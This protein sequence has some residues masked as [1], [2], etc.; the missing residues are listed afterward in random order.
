MAEVENLVLDILRRLQSDMADLKHG[1]RSIRDE[2][3]GVRQQLHVMQ[4]D[5]MSNVEKVSI[6]LTQEMAAFVRHTVESGEYASNGE[7]IRE[8]LME[9]KKRRDAEKSETETLR[10]LWQEGIDS[11]PGRFETIEDI[12]K[13]AKRRQKLFGFDTA[14]M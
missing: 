14:G 12:I 3:I 11:G 5:I 2:L 1:Q 6:A 8:A 9:W 7:I 10:T 13:E 4:G